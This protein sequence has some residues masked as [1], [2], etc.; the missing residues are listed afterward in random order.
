VPITS[1]NYHAH[2]GVLHIIDRV[3]VSIYERGGN[4]V[5]ELHKNPHYKTL[6]KLIATADLSDVLHENGP[7]TL[8]APS[9]DVFSS[10]P[11]DVLQHLI[12][13]PAVLRMVLLN[14]VV[15]GTWFLDGLEDG[16]VLT[17]L[18]KS[19]LTVGMNNDN[20]YIGNATVTHDDKLA[21]NGVIHYINSVLIPPEVEKKLK[22]I[23]IK[24]AKRKMLKGKDG[25]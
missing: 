8:F 7:F 11:A 6:A 17:T 2:N 20:V 21:S 25:D 18:Q 14:H 4:L 12:D 22:K 5:K 13:N 15:S 1:S 3:V 24:S 9:D 16:Q 23:M 10:L 19:Q